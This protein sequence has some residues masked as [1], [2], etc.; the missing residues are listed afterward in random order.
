MNSHKFVLLNSSHLQSVTEFLHKNF[1]K[2]GLEPLASML[3]DPEDEYTDTI[4]QIKLGCSDY[5][6]SGHSWGIFNENSEIL[7][8]SLNTIRVAPLGPSFS[9]MVMGSFWSC[10]RYCNSEA[11]YWDVE[12]QLLKDLGS[13]SCYKNLENGTK[14]IFIQILSISDKCRRQ[15]IGY[16]LVDH[17]LSVEKADFSVVQTTNS[18]SFGLFRKMGYSVDNQI[19]YESYR[20]SRGKLPF[21]GRLVNG[22]QK[23]SL[24]S[25]KL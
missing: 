13:Y 2:R 19:E 10:A 4:D 9:E 15:G 11:Y 3:S 18:K 1:F 12:I 23:L 6:K 20:D 16:K 5:I 24:L 8:V 7:G 22:E 14:V 21:K 17:V 25:K